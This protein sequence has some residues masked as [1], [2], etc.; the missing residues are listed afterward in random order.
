MDARN[1]RE[2][3][4]MLSAEEYRRLRRRDREV[5]CLED[6]TE[7]NLDAIRKAEAPPAATDFDHEA[8]D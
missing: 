1:G 8:T 3:L 5:L 4:A 6:F 7:A 2:R